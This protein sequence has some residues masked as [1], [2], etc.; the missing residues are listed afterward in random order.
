M[1]VRLGPLYL[2]APLAMDVVAGVGALTAVMAA[3]IALVQTD[4]KK[5]LAYSTVSQLGY[6]F[7]ACGVG[8]FGVGVFHLYTH[9]FFKALLFLGSGS[10][11]H[12]MSGEQDMRQMGGLRSRIPVTFWTFV[13]GWAAIAGLPFLSGAVSKEEILASAWHAER[14]GL[15]WVGLITAGLTAFYMSRLLFLTFFGRFRG[16]HEAEHHLHES[17]W[18]MLGP[19]VILAVGAIAAGL[20]DI[21]HI[22]RPTLRLGQ[23]EESHVA[24]LRLMLL[25]RSMHVPEWLLLPEVHG[26][27]LLASFVA[28]VGIVVAGYFYLV[29]RELPARIG[30]AL[31][32]LATALEHKW[33]FDDV[34]NWFAARVVVD[35]SRSLLWQRFDAG[36]IDG[37]VNGA[38]A[39]T[40]GIAAASRYAQTGLARGYAL[41]ILGGAVALL[42]YLVWM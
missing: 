18:S 21:P 20:V 37:L 6:M 41:L 3:T 13:A 7:L 2:R 1:V 42:G 31:R 40:S 11:I 25:S 8:A 23:P 30:A 14:H 5:V 24:G 15:F 36:F 38:G 22:V 27:L 26:L 12:A 39:V 19:L 4:I 17:P 33:F 34:Y 9:A 32:P 29:Y 16:S 35:G 28:V 10:V